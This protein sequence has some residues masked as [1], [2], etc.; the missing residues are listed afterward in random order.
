MGSRGVGFERAHRLDAAE[1]GGRGVEYFADAEAPCEKNVR[2]GD[3][4]D[5]AETICRD[6]VAVIEEAGMKHRCRVFIH[7]L[8]FL[9]PHAVPH[10]AATAGV[11]GK[12]P[13][14]AR[15]DAEARDR[16]NAVAL[17]RGAEHHSVKMHDNRKQQRE[18]NVPPEAFKVIEKHDAAQACSC[19]A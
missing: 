5:E 6:D 8:F 1:G 15:R 9:A 12:N 13:V 16:V 10:H 2:D 3:A 7:N 19:A 11:C 17:R 18:T 4:Q 14:T